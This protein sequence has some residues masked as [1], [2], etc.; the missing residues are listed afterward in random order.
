MPLVL[1]PKARPLIVSLR[2]LGWIFSRRINSPT[3]SGVAFYVH[4]ALRHPTTATL[5]PSLT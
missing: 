4:A 1:A 2:M 5:K 3:V